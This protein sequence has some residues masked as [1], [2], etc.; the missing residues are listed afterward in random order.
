MSTA[1]PRRPALIRDSV[2]NIEASPGEDHDNHYVMPVDKPRLYQWVTGGNNTRNGVTIL[3]HAGGTAGEWRDVPY[4]DRG[5]DLTD[6]AQTL[7]VSGEQWR[8]CPAGTLTQA[9]TKTLGT[10]GA[11]TAHRVLI[12]NE[13]QGYALTVANGGAGGGTLAVFTGPGYA[14]AFFDG[15]NWTLREFGGDVQTSANIATQAAWYV[16]SST[17]S[18]SAVGSS[19]APL[20]TLNGFFDRIRGV[21][22]TAAA[23]DVYLTDTADTFK[24]ENVPAYIKLGDTITFAFHGVRTSILTGTLT[25]VQNVV[26]ASGTIS[27]ITAT[28]LP[29]SWTS[30]L[31]AN[32][33]CLVRV[34]VGGGNFATCWIASDLGSKTA[35]VSDPIDSVGYYSTSLATGAFACYTLTNFGANVTFNIETGA[36]CAVVFY[37]CA[38]GD[39]GIHTVEFYGSGITTLLT[40]STVGLDVYNTRV[41][42]V[43]C[44]HTDGFRS[45]QGA[46][47]QGYSGLCYSTTTSPQAH[48]GSELTLTNMVSQGMQYLAD[49]GGTVQVEAGYWAAVFDPNVSAGGNGV[50]VVS[51]GTLRIVGRLFGTCNAAGSGVYVDVTGKVIHNTAKAIAIT[52]GTQDCLIG[53]TAKA[54]GALPFFNTSNG[55]CVVGTTFPRG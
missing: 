17:G 12:T 15:T 28:G 7:Y 38:I 43:G 42:T 29:T 14:W 35:R 55:A 30:S 24:N 3:T 37:D 44:K 41:S 25:S 8:N 10:T 49:H 9:R 51:D 2:A 32:L 16:N 23:I 46:L 40:S 48:K 27:T 53:G 54:Y 13:R 1:Y 26:E 19:T 50:D 47:L 11:R 52:G 21:M 45:Q 6:A 4:D 36:N 20:K 31:G 34:D 18:D 22:L 39:G 5:D 33:R